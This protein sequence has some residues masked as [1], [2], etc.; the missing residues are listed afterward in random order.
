[1][2]SSGAGEVEVSPGSL[3]VVELVAFEAGVE[4]ANMS[5]GE[6]A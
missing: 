3:F 2:E 4:D 6:L 1:M 5:V